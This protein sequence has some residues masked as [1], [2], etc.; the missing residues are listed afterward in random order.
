LARLPDNASRTASDLK[1]KARDLYCLINFPSS[2]FIA[3]DAGNGLL[4]A[5]VFT[6]SFSLALGFHP[7]AP[8]LGF[9]YGVCGRYLARVRAWIA[10]SLG[11][12]PK[13]NASALAFDAVHGIALMA[14]VINPAA[15]LGIGLRRIVL[16]SLTHT[17]SKGA[18]RLFLDKR[19]SVAGDEQQATGVAISTLA[20][21]CH[22]LTTSL[23][24]AGWAAAGVI[25]GALACWGVW[26]HF[27]P[28]KSGAA[29]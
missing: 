27:W 26:V 1:E 17:I 13:G 29:A 14:L 11:D 6:A 7:I 8:I 9:V 15:G 25:Q 22:G 12:G 10:F 19:F 21:F 28:R 20:D 2:L 4:G 23:M 18:L 16:T 5:A 3:R 24:Y